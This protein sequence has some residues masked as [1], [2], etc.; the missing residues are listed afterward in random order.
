MDGDP[1]DPDEQAKDEPT[2]EAISSDEESSEEEPTEE[3]PIDFESALAPPPP[4][5]T[6]STTVV[7]F[8]MENLE[9]IETIDTSEEPDFTKVERLG[10]H[11]NYF[12][13]LCM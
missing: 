7:N 2:F 12:L 13:I 1:E 6:T 10:S 9:K 3:K 8:D 5:V 4:P 11:R